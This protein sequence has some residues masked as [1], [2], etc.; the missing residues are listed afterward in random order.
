MT[1]TR[2]RDISIAIALATVGA[3][4][5]VFAQIEGDRGVPPISSEGDFQVDGVK[6]DVFADSSERARDAG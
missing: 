4:A 3:G 5:M 2:F 6:V 1:R